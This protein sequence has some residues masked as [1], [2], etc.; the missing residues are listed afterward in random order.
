MHFELRKRFTCFGILWLT[1]CF[2]LCKSNKFIMKEIRSH[3]L[4]FYILFVQVQEEIVII[5]V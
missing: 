4:D 5:I 3:L 2:L 1:L